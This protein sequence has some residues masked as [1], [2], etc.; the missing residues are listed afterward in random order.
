MAYDGAFSL[1]G[2]RI[3]PVLYQRAVFK[4]NPYGIRSSFRDGSS[5]DGVAAF[6][7][8][9]AFRLNESEHAHYAEVVFQREVAVHP[10]GFD[11]LLSLRSFSFF[12]GSRTFHVL[13]CRIPVVAFRS[14]AARE[15]GKG[16]TCPK[17]DVDNKM[18]HNSL[19]L[20]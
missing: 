10:V 12:F 15:G 9:Q 18:F 1:S 2:R 13:F 19:S 8:L 5:I 20:M 3:Y 17:A 7:L 16:E 11:L 6:D 4:D 14:V